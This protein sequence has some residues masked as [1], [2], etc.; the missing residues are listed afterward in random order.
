VLGSP[1]RHS[2]SPVMHRAAYRRLGLTWSFEVTTEQLPRFL[3]GLDGTWRGLSLTMP[4]KRAVLPLLDDLD[5]HARRSGAANT[6]V[7]EEGRRHGFN[8]DVPG[9]SA[10]MAAHLH[11]VDS[12]VV[13]GAGAT[14]ASVVLALADRRC[15]SVRLAVRDPA[16]ARQT[17][18]VV[19]GH[20]TPPEVEVVDLAGLHDVVADLV[21]STIPPAAQTAE[22]VGALDHV[23]AVFEV[24]YDPWPSPLARAA[25]D[26]HRTF[27]SGIEMLG[28]QAELQVELMT[29]RRVDAGELIA[30]AEAQLGLLAD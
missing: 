13:L 3:D 28:H 8:T 9:A 22:V 26:S 12:A 5:E 4:L 14:A 23:P 27:I 1:I 11:A 29:G 6:V 21:V 19:W 17:V 30:A 7:L 20:P 24:V 18:E 25:L 10:A 15:T 16:R 2:L